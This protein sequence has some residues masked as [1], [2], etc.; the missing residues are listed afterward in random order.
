MGMNS[1]NDASIPGIRPSYE[2]E[3]AYSHRNSG[4]L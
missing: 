3:T 4:L 2:K 1:E